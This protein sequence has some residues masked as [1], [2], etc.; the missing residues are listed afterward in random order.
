MS[1]RVFF[2]PSNSKQRTIVAWA[3]TYLALE[4]SAKSICTSESNRCGNALNVIP[5]NVQPS[6]RLSDTSTTDKLRRCSSKLCL[7]QTSEIAGGHTCPLCKRLD[8]KILIKVTQNP[9]GYI[10]EAVAGLN[11]KL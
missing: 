8:R 1:L 5:R 3:T 2:F 10:R 6:L 9:S 4:C 11:L 7:E